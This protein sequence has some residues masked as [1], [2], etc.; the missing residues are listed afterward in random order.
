M[1]R[2]PWYG[3]LYYLLG[4]QGSFFAWLIAATGVYFT[5]REAVLFALNQHPRDATVAEIVTG[6]SRFKRWV[7]VGGVE[8]D[9]GSALFAL[10]GAGGDATQP[11][12]AER[13]IGGADT[14]LIDR[15]DPAAA[16]WRDLFRRIETLAAE[17]AGET[18]AAADRRLI[19]LWSLIHEVG[20]EKERARFVPRQALV[21]VS[22]ATATEPAPPTPTARPTGTAAGGRGPLEGAGPE[23]ERASLADRW[24]RLTAERVALIRRA[25]RVD[26]V[27]EG[28]LEPYA[29]LERKYEE[30]YRVK[31]A[32][33]ALVIGHRPS[34]I[35]A[36]LFA[37]FA[38]ILTFL[39]VGLRALGQREPGGA[40]GTGTTPPEP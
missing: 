17:P 11:A 19:D 30:R 29:G 23:R 12:A 15:D 13:A 26:V 6:E 31:V 16:A 2:R 3:F 33:S 1:A 22:P 25:V 24:R 40:P 39:V 34:P 27:R 21:V 20:T 32:R 28:L 38:L 35:L 7:Q 14:V 10:E 37:F 4:A 8:I 18:E 9:L 5:S 36:V